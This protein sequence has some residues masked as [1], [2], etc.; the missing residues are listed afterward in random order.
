MTDPD[1]TE[2]FYLDGDANAENNREFIVQL[3]QRAQGAEEVRIPRG[4]DEVLT[5]GVLPNPTNPRSPRVVDVVL[6]TGRGDQ[7]RSLTLRIQRHDL[8]ILDYWVGQENWHEF[9]DKRKKDPLITNATFL[10]KEGTYYKL[11]YNAQARRENISLGQSTLI[12]AI[13]DPFRVENP[14]TKEEKRKAIKTRTHALIVIIQMISESMRIH[15]MLEHIHTHWDGAREPPSSIIRLENEWG[16]DSGHIRDY[17]RNPDAPPPT[18][19]I[20]P[21]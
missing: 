11:E 14:S 20:R 18:K 17:T 6:H 21:T 5:I 12:N 8:Y 9:G 19:F 4:A 15:P 2:H 16:T 7:D 13:H 1:F 10:Q 3:R